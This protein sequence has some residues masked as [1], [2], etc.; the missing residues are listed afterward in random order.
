MPVTTW[1]GKDGSITLIKDMPNDHLVNAYKYLIRM[2]CTK[3][4]DLN[5]SDSSLENEDITENDHRYFYERNRRD[6]LDLLEQKDSIYAEM[7]RRGLKI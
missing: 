6:L 3:R 5:A 1:R 7:C 2:V 4:N